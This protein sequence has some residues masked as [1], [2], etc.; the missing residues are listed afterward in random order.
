MRK[1][2]VVL[3]YHLVC[4]FEKEKTDTK[5]QS[6]RKRCIVTCSYT[7]QSITLCYTF[8]NSPDALQAHI[9][10]LFP[11]QQTE[12]TIEVKSNIH[13]LKKISSLF[14]RE[15]P[16]GEMQQ[17]NTFQK[18]ANMLVLTII[19]ICC[20]LSLSFQNPVICNFSVSSLFFKKAN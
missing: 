13:Q 1:R 9:L 12:N 17:Y 15:Q 6:E 20:M 3:Q 11:L 4:I 5:G 14:S 8:S 18:Q 19:F 10:H 7:S 16:Q 2:E